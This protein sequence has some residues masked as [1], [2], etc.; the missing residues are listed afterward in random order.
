MFKQHVV[1]DS[2][3]S[4]FKQQQHDMGDATVKN[5]SRLVRELADA[6]EAEGLEPEAAAETAADFVK[7]F[8]GDRCQAQLEHFPR[9]CELARASPRGLSN[10]IGLFFRAVKDNWR[11]PAYPPDDGQSHSWYTDDEAGLIQ[12]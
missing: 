12:R 3:S 6:F 8:G 4:E 9:H 10:P 2:D 5:Y 11:P 7:Q 1:V